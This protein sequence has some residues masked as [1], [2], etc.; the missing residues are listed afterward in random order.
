[1]SRLWNRLLNQR[2]VLVAVVIGAILLITA[3]DFFSDSE[4]RV[5]PLYDLPISL[6]AWSFG[7]QGCKQLAGLEFSLPVIWVAI[8]FVQG[9]SF[10]F[11]GLLMAIRLCPLLNNRSFQKEG[12]RLV[13]LCQRSKRPITLA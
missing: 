3:V 5:F 12:D 13:A 9:T 11:V 7:W 2:A 4:L 1:M 8:T 6:A 10:A